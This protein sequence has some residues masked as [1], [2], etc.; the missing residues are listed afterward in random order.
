MD[1][2][3]LHNVNYAQPFLHS[4]CKEFEQRILVYVA[5]RICHS[6]VVISVFKSEQLLWRQGFFQKLH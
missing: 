3:A 6:S 1:T 4:I 5:K 2:L